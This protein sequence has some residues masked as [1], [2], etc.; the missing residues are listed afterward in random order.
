M[1]VVL[2]LNAGGSWMRFIAA[3]NY[4]L[5]LI[6]QCIISVGAAPVSAIGPRNSQNFD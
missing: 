1:I 6:G 4:N 3:D 5:V 2:V